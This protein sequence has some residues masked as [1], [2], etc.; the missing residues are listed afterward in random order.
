L[1]LK[2]QDPYN[3]PRILIIDDQFGRC[4]LGEAFRDFVDAKIFSAYQADRRNLCLNFGL[5]EENE[6]H[7]AKNKAGEPIAVA[8]FC[9]GQKWNQ[10]TTRIENDLASVIRYVQQGWPFADGSR[11]SL[12]LLDLAFVYGKLDIFGDPQERSLFGRDVILPELKS[13]FGADLPIVVL[14]STP[15]EIN[16]PAV[17]QGGALDF[18]QRIPGAGAPANESE[19]TLKKMLFFHGL[20]QDSTGKIAGKSLPTLKMLRQA[21]RAAAAGKTILLYGETG[22]GKN[23]L[24]EYIHQQSERRD[25]PLEVF[26]ASMRPPHLQEDELFGH[27]KGA[28][29]GAEKSEPGVWERA[30]GGVVFIDEV[31]SLD[32]GVQLK[33]MEPIES[34]RIKRM[35]HPP[36]GKG[37]IDID[38]MAILATN[39]DPE[40]LRQ[41]GFLKHDFLNRINANVLH[42]PP[43]REKK[44]DI[45]Y[46]VTALTKAENP[47]WQGRI[48]QAAM[49]KLWEY[50]WA[51]GNVRELRNVLVSAFLNNPDQDITA[52]DINI[53][54]SQAVP[55]EANLISN[56]TGLL[57]EEFLDLLKVSPDT[58]T[59]KERQAYQQKYHEA[60]ADLMAHILSWSLKLNE[61]VS[62]TARFL[63]GCS[64]K[65]MDASAARQFIKKYLKL[66]TKGKR[67]VKKFALYPEAELS[68]I[69]KIIE[70]A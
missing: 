14:S 19:E 4:D 30:N 37:A 17:R 36:E 48:Y 59:I 26:N 7:L 9:P 3:L 11:W 35:G 60:F 42:L 41:S 43:L 32:A 55:A 54:S 64:E 66:D 47:G 22:T 51:E 1:K 57:W 28:F 31:A 45:P 20:L 2:I 33:L 65:E 8:T 21:R 68:T 62:N 23:L 52:D 6:Y 44:E 56:E 18:I 58:L 29:T 38:V 5:L 46:L 27:W 16:N 69:K 24:A 13:Q 39:R 50:S 67:I 10:S 25:K 34:R 53:S 15:K 12:V 49:D 61:N 70:D 40:A 63:S